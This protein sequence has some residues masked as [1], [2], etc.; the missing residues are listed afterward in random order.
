MKVIISPAKKMNID[1]EFG[2]HNL[3]YFLDKTELLMKH[4]QR[5]S[6][7][8][9][10]SLWKCND[11]IAR[12][13]FE[14]FSNMCLTERLTPAILAYE[15]IQYQYMSP[16]VFNSEQLDY[17]ENHLNILSGFYGILKPFDGVVPYRL[18]MQAPIKL[19]GYKDLYDF[20]DNSLFSKLYEDTDVVLNLASKEYSKCV[21]NHLNKNAQFISCTFGEYKDGKI[22]TKGTLAKMA[23]G[24]MVRY[25]AENKVEKISEIKNFNRLDYKYSD[26]KSNSR[27]IVFIKE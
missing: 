15:G 13:S 6:Y 21:E 19:K 22:I 24:E 12:T 1:T 10:K 14:Y 11:K 20:W 27:N 17:L 26:E 5:L 2:I 25:M 3:P 16:N 9:A 8:E 18:E 23:R 7:E 4:I